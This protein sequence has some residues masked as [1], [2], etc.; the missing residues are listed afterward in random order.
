M[1]FGYTL[2]TS[3]NLCSKPGRFLLADGWTYSLYVAIYRSIIPRVHLFEL[4]IQ[5]S[6]QIRKSLELKLPWLA[7]YPGTQ[8]VLGSI[9][10]IL[11]THTHSHTYGAGIAQWYSV[12]LR[13]GWS[14]VRVPVR[15]R[16]FLF[17]TA[18]RLALGPTQPPIQWVPGNLF[19][20]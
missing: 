13:A 18:S 3:L 11:H 2:M 14:G 4:K 7:Y 17:T 20:V 9:S 16:N 1:H 10:T 8:R 12:G 15:T 19:L 6:N 5:F